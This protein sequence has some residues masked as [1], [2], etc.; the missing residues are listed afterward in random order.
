MVALV[1]MCNVSYS[2]AVET[3]T[4]RSF[5]LEALETAAASPT[6]T[7]VSILA[8]LAKNFGSS[9]DDNSATTQTSQS[10]PVHD[11]VE[12]KIA[13]EAVEKLLDGGKHNSTSKPAPAEKTSDTF[14]AGKNATATSHPTDKVSTFDMESAITDLMMGKQSLGATPMGSSIKK[15]KQ[16]IEK[17]MMPAG[18]DGH[19]ADQKELNQLGKHVAHCGDGRKVMWR[20]VVAFHMKY[21]KFS[22]L[23]KACRND[24]AIKY[25]AKKNCFK[26]LAEKKKIKE[27]RCNFY[28]MTSRRVGDGNRNR[29]IVKRGGS[30]A[31]EVYVRRITATTCGQAGG[32]GAGGYG[33][34]GMLDDLLVAKAKC[35]K[36]LKEYNAQGKKCARQLKDYTNRKAKCNMIQVGMDSSAC[37]SAV[38]AKDSCETYA[39]CHKSKSESYHTARKTIVQEEKDRKAEWRGLKRMGCFINAFADGRVRNDEIEACKKSTVNTKHLGIK[40]PQLPKF[41]TCSIPLKY[42]STPEYKKAE[43]A[44][45]PAVAKGRE[46]EECTGVQ[47]I[48]TKPNAGSPKSCKCSRVTLNGPY[49]PGPLVKCENCLTVRRSLDKNSCPAG[50]K[51]FSPRSRTDW[52]TFIKSARPLRAPHFIIDVT[53]PQNS[54]GGCTRHPM[55]SGNAQQKT[56]RTAD[57]TPWWLRSTRYSEPIAISTCGTHLETPMRSHGM[58]GV[59]HIIQSLII[60]SARGTLQSPNAEAHPHVVVIALTWQAPIQRRP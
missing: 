2:G 32:K 4:G 13:D 29:Q 12:S 36:A 40:Y 41:E 57:G 33:K 15:I 27:L 43:Y 45:L 38:H 26:D 17:T 16:L 3:I 39:E 6:M 47:E 14:G 35:E 51:I 1:A 48:S 21:Q 5:A 19:N 9:D 52:Q 59:A 58:M 46:S 34:R 7:S 8:Q 53:R 60:A 30:E 11:S 10:S 22:K 56:W 23:H 28:A 55:N 24:E 49:S 44:D 31:T 20:N 50:T 18:L 37:K 25:T 42:P 54:C